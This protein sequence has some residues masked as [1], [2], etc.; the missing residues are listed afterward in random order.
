MTIEDRTKIQAELFEN[1]D[2]SKVFRPSGLYVYFMKINRNTGIRLD[3]AEFT[4]FDLDTEVYV[5]DK[6]RLV[7]E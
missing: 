5:F 3:T 4:K 1:V 6:V 2:I 7:I